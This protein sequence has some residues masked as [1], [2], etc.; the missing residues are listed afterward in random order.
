[1]LALSCAAFRPVG[2]W[3][4][5]AASTPCSPTGSGYHGGRHRRRAYRVVAHRLHPCR[6]S[7]AGIAGTSLSRHGKIVKVATHMAAATSPRRQKAAD[8]VDR[9]VRIRRALLQDLPDAGLR[10]FLDQLGGIWEIIF[11]MT[12]RSTRVVSMRLPMSLIAQERAAPESGRALAQ[13]G[14]LG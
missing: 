7:T 11:W 13:R 8:V 4:P 14:S 12:H 10:R 2:A 3:N 6:L 9:Q 5:R 1:M